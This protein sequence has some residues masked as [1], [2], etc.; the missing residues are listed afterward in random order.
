MQ[1]AI[2]VFTGLLPEP[3]NGQVVKMLFVLSHWHGLAKLRMH[4]DETLTIMEDVTQDLGYNLRSF[5]ETCSVF[6]T[7]EL[8]R[9]AESRIRQQAR[10]KNSS[11]ARSQINIA[12][13]VT[14]SGRRTKV[15]NLRTYKL[16]ALGDYVAQIRL[17]GT[18]DS[19]STQPVRYFSIG[20]S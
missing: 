13:P 5:N 11:S 15:L 3:H 19:F 7:R 20:V 4:T 16:H 17:Y 10:S 18:T 12:A 1:C 14:T 6:S 8:R 2:P 9:E